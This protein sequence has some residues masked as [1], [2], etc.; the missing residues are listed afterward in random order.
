MLR[1]VPTV[2][3]GTP[4][5]NGP[6]LRH[7]A[8]FRAA[9]PADAAAM[10]AHLS[11]L[12]AIPHAG[13]LEVAMNERPDRLATEHHV[14][15]HGEFAGPAALAAFRAHPLYA[16]V[17]RRIMALRQDRW[18]VDY[19]VDAETAP[20]APGTAAAGFTGQG[21]TGQAFPGAAAALPPLP[22]FG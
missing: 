8:M 1:P 2:P 7:L 20:V 11:V 5:E 16:I 10:L 4:P 18:A 15:L 3:P 17:A 14:V 13:R 9:C 12:K 6:G 22:T 21:F 19:A